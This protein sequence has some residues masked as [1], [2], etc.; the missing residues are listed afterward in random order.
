MNI[1]HV[2]TKVW[3]IKC[4]PKAWTTAINQRLVLSL[5]WG[6]WYS[7]LYWENPCKENHYTIQVAMLC[8]FVWRSVSLNDK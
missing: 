8:M 6:E 5:K 2:W 1:E 3:S 7:V 4:D